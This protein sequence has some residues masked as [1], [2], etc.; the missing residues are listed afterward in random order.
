MTYLAYVG[1]FFLVAT[2]I[3][4]LFERFRPMA[5]VLGAGMALVFAIL[6]VLT[7]RQVETWKSSEALWSN[8][9]RLYPRSDAA[10]ISRG[11]GRGA[12]GQI[13]G[14]MSDFRIAVGLGS[15]RADLFDGLGNAYGTLGMPDSALLMFDRA[16]AIDSTLGRT[17]YNRAIVHLRLGRPREA[18]E[19]LAKA[20]EV[21]PLQ[22]PTLHFPRGNAFLQLGQ[23]RDAETEFGR[24]I[25]AGQLV[26]DALANRG[27]CRLR[28]NDLAGARSDFREALRIDPNYSLA[29]EQLRALG[30]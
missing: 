2:G 7:T 17:Y 12:A 16:L 25:E 8:V 11:N 29:R 3:G 13:Q 4:W 26:P 19:D 28:L 30:E 5:A 1:P 21:I 10:Y 9:I 18:L 22:A 6:F 14:A 20:Q 27:V 24:A 15:R 23:Y